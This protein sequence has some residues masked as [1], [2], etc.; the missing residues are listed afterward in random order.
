[1]MT[2]RNCVLL[3]VATYLCMIWQC[4]KNSIYICTCMYLHGPQYICIMHLECMCIPCVMYCIV[5]N[6]HILVLVKISVHM[7][8]HILH[9]L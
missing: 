3:N 8:I 2:V 1:M 9:A 6:E 4:Y 5:M 7:R